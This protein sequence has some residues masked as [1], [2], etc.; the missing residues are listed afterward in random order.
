MVKGSTILV[1][2]LVAILFI[3]LIGG[4]LFFGII[5]QAG[6]GGAVCSGGQVLSIDNANIVFSNELQK[7]VVRVTFSTVPTSECLDIQISP[8]ELNSKLQGEDF[9]ATET[10]RGDI[11]LTRSDK[12]FN[13]V[14][15]N[16]EQFFRAS[17]QNIGDPFLCTESACNQRGATSTFAS[18]REPGFFGSGDCLCAEDDLRG[19]G[20]E[21]QSSTQL[22]WRTVISI[23]NDELVLENNRQSG[24]VGNIAFVKWAG[25]LRG[26]R[27]L[28][29][30]NRDLYKPFTT[31]Q[32]RIVDKQTY[33]DLNNRFEGVRSE[34]IARDNFGG[35]PEQAISNA[36]SYN[37][38]FD[39]NTRD[40]L[41]S[42]VGSESLVSDANIIGNQ[43]VAILNSPIV[44]PQFTLDIDAD[45]VGI[46][47]SVGEPDVSCPSDFNIVSGET[48][49]AD[50]QVKNVGSDSGS[51]SYRVECDRGS[52]AVNPAPPIS[53]GSG[54]SKTVTGEFGLTVEGEQETASCTFT[55]TE[56]N[57]LE[58]DSCRFEYTSTKQTQCIEGAQT[59]ELGNTQLWT[60]EEDGSFNKITCEFGCESFEDEVRCRLQANEICTDGIDND[61]DGLIDAD[62]PECTETDCPPIFGFL[63]NIP[64]E[65]SNFLEDF[66]ILTS[67]IIG[68]LVAIFAG[69][70]AFRGLD[71][72]DIKKSISRGAQILF[73]VIIGILV[74]ILVA[75]ITFK[76]FFL[77]LI[78][79][80]VLIILRLVF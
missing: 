76:F 46:F 36:R 25:N 26:N 47:I 55:T 14:Q 8:S 49:N 69:L 24:R 11:I 23:G 39:S 53:I 15:D 28:Q 70:L 67:I 59:C 58:E 64:C 9:Q 34:L 1:S 4:A 57:T 77:G 38:R 6:V 21:F 12:I 60:C 63:P 35:D 5:P 10:I 78:A 33:S 65:I 79:L 62:D 43:L 32:W 44:Y 13:I 56:L 37:S 42:W 80:I 66:R 45:E 52:V 16:N 74:G 61:G 31:N 40:G 19:I 2:V 7:D 48:Q 68:L 75:F 17:L 73:A 18:V 54:S 50:F 30:I 71:T 72:S 22:Q 27:E 41:V 51:F 20:G 3:G 29:S